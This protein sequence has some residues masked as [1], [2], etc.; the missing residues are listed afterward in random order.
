MANRVNEETLMRLSEDPFQTTDIDPERADA[1]LAGEN[2]LLHMVLKREPLPDILETLC[3][4]AEEATT[5]SLSS[6]L[7]VAPDGKH[8]SRGAAPSLPLIFAQ[9]LDTSPIAAG[10][11]PC[12]LAALEAQQVIVANFELD[13]RW[14]AGYRQLALAHGLRAC[15]VEPIVSVGGSV[16]GTFALYYREPRT[17]KP[18]EQDIIRHFMYIA[19]TAIERSQSEDAFWRI[20]AYQAEAQRLSLTGSFSWDVR[21][22]EVMWSAETFRIYGYD[23]A[24]KPTLELARKRLHPDDLGL[25][26]ETARRA[27]QDGNDIDFG[28]RLLMPDGSIKWLEIR[29]TAVRDASGELVEYIGAVRDVTEQHRSLGAIAMN[30]NACLRSLEDGSLNLEEAREAARRSIRDAKRAAE[31]IARSGD[32]DATRDDGLAP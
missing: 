15:W 5:G 22:G 21:T 24:M 8:L 16:L 26:N 11:G 2:R 13:E 31:V 18:A 14:S 28:H 29:A 23:T 25:F 20:Q 27:R 12:G 7:L 3:R 1:M 9:Q 30:A 19:S 6:I 4:V 32:P 10:A 17:P